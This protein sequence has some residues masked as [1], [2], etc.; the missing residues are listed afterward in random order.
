MSQWHVIPLSQE[1]L[2]YAA[3]DAYVHGQKD[4]KLNLELNVIS[5]QASLLLYQ[6]LKK[7]ENERGDENRDT[8]NFLHS[9]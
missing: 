9:L 8:I 4:N 1:Q 7:K 3:T 6:E 2:K 5:L